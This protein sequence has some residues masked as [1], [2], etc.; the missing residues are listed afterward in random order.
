MATYH[1]VDTEYYTPLAETGAEETPLRVICMGNMERNY[2]DLIKIISDCP[3]MQFIVCMGKNDISSLFAGLGNVIL[4]GFLDEWQLLRIMQHSD[5]SLNVMKDTV[6]SNVLQLFGMRSCGGASNV[7][8]IGDYI[9]DRKNGI[10]FNCNTEAVKALRNLARKR[11]ELFRMQ[12]EARRRAE[13]LGID[14]F[15]RWF[16]NQMLP[17][18]KTD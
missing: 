6:G 15:I 8:S 5:V 3:E 1:Y 16:E 13:E 10:L 14:G 18:R 17:K 9:Q 12:T 7:G 2:D 11:T 4:H